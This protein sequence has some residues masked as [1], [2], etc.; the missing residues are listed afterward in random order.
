[1]KSSEEEV[2]KFLLE[3]KKIAAGE[4]GI[5]LIP[6]NET[7][8][9]LAKLGL[10]KRNLEEILLSLSTVDYC[11][12]PEE[13]D[14]I[15]RNG[16][17]WFFGKEIEGHEIYIKLKIEKIKDIEIAKCISFHIANYQLRYSYK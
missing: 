14:G 7:R 2:R 17:M 13:D 9:T 12:G 6:R 1:M 5:T 16:E 8:S 3:F 10:T 15:G 4:K 11:K